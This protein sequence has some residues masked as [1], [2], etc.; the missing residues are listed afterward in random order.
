M[1]VARSGVQRTAFQNMM[2]EFADHASQSAKAAQQMQGMGYG[3]HIEKRVADIGG[4]REAVG[5]KL[6]PSKSLSGHKQQSQRE[7]DVKPARGIFFAAAHA[8]HKCG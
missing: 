3:Q 1:P 8:S 7:S 5:A 4:K 6:H 2:A